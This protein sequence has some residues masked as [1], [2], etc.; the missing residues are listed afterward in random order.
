MRSTD[1]VFDTVDHN[2][3]GL[4]ETEEEE[5]EGGGTIVG[6]NFV[7]LH[8]FLNVFLVYLILKLS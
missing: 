6:L 2:F 3:S 1:S 5:E 7:T 4:E 8:I